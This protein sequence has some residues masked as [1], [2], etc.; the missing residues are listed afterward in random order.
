LLL[1]LL[2]LLSRARFFSLFGF[3]SGELDFFDI[4][5]FGANPD[6]DDVEGEGFDEVED[7]F[8]LDSFSELSGSHSAITSSK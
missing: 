2:L 5:G 7:E 8:V 1:L 6:D 3:G 4:N